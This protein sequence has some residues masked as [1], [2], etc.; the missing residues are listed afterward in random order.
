MTATHQDASADSQSSPLELMT[1][2]E[3]AAHIRRSR[4]GVDKLRARDSSFPKPM[5][6]GED[7]RSRVYFVKAEI[8]AWIMSKLQQRGV[9]A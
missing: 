9:A 8:D 7:R 5:K 3:L 1:V 4:S 6:V 2:A